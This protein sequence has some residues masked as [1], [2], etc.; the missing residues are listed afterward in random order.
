[1]RSIFKSVFISLFPAFALYI[2]IDSSIQIAKLGLSTSYLG[3]II[4]SLS[5]VLFFADLFLKP[6]A[7]T[8]RKLIVF[9]SIITLGLIISVFIV[10]LYENQDLLGSSTSIL[11]FIG[12]WLY[13]KWFSVFEKRDKNILKV[14][15][16]LPNFEVE[17]VSKSKINSTSF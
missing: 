15:N 10:V 12:W 6:T 9:T 5:I 11:L 16:Q 4:I 14:S 8:S 2:F 17:D 13:I 3:R 1:M 7:R